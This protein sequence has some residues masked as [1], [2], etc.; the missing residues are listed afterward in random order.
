M[1]ASLRGSARTISTVVLVALTSLLGSS[2]TPHE[3]DCHEGLCGASVFVHDAST[4]SVQASRESAE[5]PLHCV[6]CHAGRSFQPS[7]E[8]A[9]HLAPSP[10]RTLRT[11]LEVASVPSSSPSSRPP[12]RS[13]PLFHT[14]HA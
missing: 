9:H 8:S 4:H 14:L 13:P 6:I 2:F 11:Q 10:A 7:A 12:L 1:L 5:H 3:D